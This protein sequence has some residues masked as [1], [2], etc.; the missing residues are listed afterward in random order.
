MK[1]VSKDKPY[2]DGD[3]KVIETYIKYEHSDLDGIIVKLSITGPSYTN[4]CV[5][6]FPYISDPKSYENRMNFHSMDKKKLKKLYN[7][8]II[9]FSKKEYNYMEASN[10][11]EAVNDSVNPK[12]DAGITLEDVLDKISLNLLPNKVR[13]YIEENFDDLYS[14][15]D[16]LF[17]PE[18]LILKSPK[19]LADYF[20]FVYEVMI[21][22]EELDIIEWGEYFKKYYIKNLL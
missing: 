7:K 21:N 22:E 10:L 14:Y 17:D 3:Y 1:I 18:K 15:F 4:N 16:E 5:V 11:L 8:F 20:N 9:I 6:L 19:D 13:T 12:I 2:M